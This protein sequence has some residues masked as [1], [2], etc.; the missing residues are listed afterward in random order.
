MDYFYQPLEKRIKLSNQNDD[1]LVYIQVKITDLTKQF[2]DKIETLEKKVKDMPNLKKLNDSLGQIKNLENKIQSLSPDFK[3]NEEYQTLL[4]NLESKIETMQKDSTLV[5]KI[6][7]AVKQKLDPTIKKTQDL[8][9]QIKQNMPATYTKTDID[10]KLKELIYS[11]KL[12]SEIDKKLS[13]SLNPK[14]K[15]FIEQDLK[16]KNGTLLKKISS[17]VDGKLDKKV[18]DIVTPVEK[19]IDVLLGDI[20]KFHDFVIDSF[21][22]NEIKI[23]QIDHELAK[24][25]DKK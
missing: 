6:N 5:E 11:T 1:N 8:M 3:K 19:K 2:K 16:N 9:N 24:L 7:E 22:K 18:K 17:D 25:Q 14:I 4:A 23:E 13:S 20:R 15:A 21:G 12:Q 10:K